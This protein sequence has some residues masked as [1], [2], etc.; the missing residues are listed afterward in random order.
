VILVS[1]GSDFWAVTSLVSFSEYS[2]FPRIE[3]SKFRNIRRRG[4]VL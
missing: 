3:L 1:K 4:A 2:C